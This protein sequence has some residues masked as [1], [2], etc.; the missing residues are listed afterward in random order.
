MADDKTDKHIR[1]ALMTIC[2]V[3]YEIAFLGLILKNRRRPVAYPH[4]LISA[5][6]LAT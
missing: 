4:R 6:V 1:F 5:F 3:C 2:C